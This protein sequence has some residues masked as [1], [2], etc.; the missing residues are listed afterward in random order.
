MR[1]PSFNVHRRGNSFGIWPFRA[2]AER[3][4]SRRRQTRR[5]SSR[6][7]VQPLESRCVLSAAPVLDTA[8]APALGSI[9]EDA[10]APAGVV[11]TLV[12][13]LIDAG[14]PLNNFSDAD[15][16]LPGIALTGTNLQGGTLWYSVNGGTTWLDV[17][18]VSAL[19]PRYLAADATTRLY[20]EPAANSSGTLADVISFKAWDRTS[21]LQQIGLDI[22]GE[23]AGDWS[24]IS[25]SLSAD[26]STVAIGARNNVDAG[27]LISGHVRVYRWSGTTWAQLGTDI[28]GEAAYD[29]SGSS[30][31]L[32]AAGTTVAIGA[33]LNDGNG[34]NSGQTR[35]YGWDGTAWEQLGAD[36]D[37]EAASDESGY[38]VSLSADATTVAIG[39][40]LNDGNGDE[41]GHVRV[42]RWTGTD[43]A[44]L[45]ADIDGEGEYDQSGSSISL[46]ADGTTV[47][48]G[49]PYNNGMAAGH[50]RVYRWSGLGW[51][52]LGADLDGEAAYD[53]S[54]SSVS[55]SADGHTVAIGAPYNGG[56]G[57][58]SGQVRIYRWA[59]DVWEQLGDDI[60][61]EAADDHSYAVSLS[62]DGTTVAIGAPYN[63][64]NG[65]GSGHVRVYRWSGTG[66]SRLGAD[67][68]GEAGGDYAGVTLAL[69]ADGSSVAVGAP[70]NDGSGLLAGHVR[71]YRLVPQA[72]SVS[73]ATDTVSVAVTRVNDAPV[74]L[75]VSGRV[76]P[77]NMPAGSVVGTF[78]TIDPDAGDTF[79]YSLVA[80]PGSADNA[81]FTIVGDQLQTVGPLNFERRF[82]YQI[83]VRSTDA[84]GLGV[85]QA[86]N[87]GVSDQPAEPFMVESLVPP[88][89]GLRRAGQFVEVTLVTS[90]VAT[91]RLLPQVPIRVGGVTRLATYVAGSGTT[92][93][94]FRYRVAAGD[95]GPVSLAGR[96]VLPT[97]AAVVSSGRRLPLALPQAAFAGLVVDT[98]PPQPQGR[99]LVPAAAMYGTNATL[100]FTVRFSEPV[101][102]TGIPRL[103]LTINAAAG[104]RQATYVSGSGTHE[105]VFEYVVQL[106]DRT[107][108]TRGILVNARLTL[109]VGS[110][111]TDAAG[112]AAVATLLL[113]PTGGIRVDGS[114]GSG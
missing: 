107:P 92:E 79:T 109:P 106:G 10:E 4:D 67:L 21:I 2:W 23:A 80:G 27:G 30:V 48:I 35:I 25:V 40:R 63:D 12:S 60:D 16:D 78:S 19:A 41:S 71:V 98:R 59:N 113:P 76:I 11:G 49:A 46:S 45:G 57:P 111:I 88:A 56:N 33:V 32:S 18:T 28:N 97:G 62:A 54:G 105:L 37:G 82:A 96:L 89:A 3:R 100:R 90:T 87:I 5:R 108:P 1:Q 68:D 101:T 110:R 50:V 81:V 52:Q 14:G 42:Y 112:N 69:S 77:E 114:L 102:V 6:L 26:G 73:A 86:L 65:S 84:G 83:R 55:L 31:S 74:S 47:A 36:I 9:F 43:W 53:W 66:W 24:G 44:R 51:S 39:S 7:Q 103:G 61:G 17:G 13:S 99:L 29:W 15:G 72:D 91:V 75:D 8:A 95:N 58:N 93:L 85:E 22:D 20:F 94:T 34:E 70:G 104:N 64:G 38:S